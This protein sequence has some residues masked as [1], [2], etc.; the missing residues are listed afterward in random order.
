MELKQIRPSDYD[1]LKKFFDKQKYPLC[2]YSLPSILVWSGKSHQP[3]G[4]INGDTLIVCVE[5]DATQEKNRHM[6][7]PISPNGESSPEEL[8]DFAKQIAFERY[9][10][11]PEDYIER[12]G[13]DR[14]EALFEIQEQAE[15]EDYIYLTEDLANLK[16]NKYAKKR[17]LIKQFKREYLQKDRVRVKD[18][19]NDDV[20]ECLDFMKKWCEERDCDADPEADLACEKE[21]AINALENIEILDVSGTLLRVDDEVCAFGIISHL[22]EDMAA[23]HFEKAFSH[24]KGLYQF[25]DS[26]CAKQL[27]G[28]YKYINK[29]SDMGIPGLAKAKRSY[30]PAMMLKSYKLTIR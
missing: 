26:L 4:A 13:R 18:I 14:V 7:L 23:M 15:L 3:Y 25:F 21:A 2:A 30:H 19:T 28:K 29:E 27:L 8:S 10:F 20:P 5:F 24:I 12:F 22:T 6:I 17:N 11:V 16:G 9:W 1:S